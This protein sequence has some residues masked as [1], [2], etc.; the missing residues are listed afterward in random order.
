M[1]LI[2]PEFIKTKIV[3][4]HR[5]KKISLVV[6]TALFSYVGAAN[7]VVLIHDNF[8]TTNTGMNDD[9]ATRQTGSLAQTTWNLNS[10]ADGRSASISNNTMVVRASASA[11]TTNNSAMVSLNHSFTD[12]AIINAGGFTVSFDM[13]QDFNNSLL[14]FGL[15]LSDAGRNETGSANNAHNRASTDWGFSYYQNNNQTFVAVDGVS[16][17]NFTPVPVGTWFNV[18]IDVTTANFNSG[19]TATVNFFIN[20]VLID[21]NRSF[22]WDGD[23]TNYLALSG[24]RGNNPDLAIDNFSVT[25]V[26]EPT[27]A[28]LGGLGM[29][30]LLRRR[31]A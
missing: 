19:T 4:I 16:V 15:G 26:P 29:L 14:S 20:D 27:T 11:G 21:G 25:V 12:A 1:N 7:A 5:M 24:Y 18:T 3:R 30:F 13:K 8:N 28:L 10:T 22:T 23:G 31:R 9:L 6:T 2:L 17:L